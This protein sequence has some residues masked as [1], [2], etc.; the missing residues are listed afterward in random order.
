MDYFES[1]YGLGPVS[2]LL[3]YPKIQSTEKMGVYLQGSTSFDIDFISVG[4][5]TAGD[6]S[7]V[8]EPH[9]FYAYCAAM[10]GVHP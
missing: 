9:C 10:R 6:K 4:E 2:R 7:P 5:D 3:I 8:L 1:F